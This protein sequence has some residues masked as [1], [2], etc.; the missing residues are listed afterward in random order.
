M[1]PLAFIKAMFKKTT[2]ILLE[3]SQII[4]TEN[5]EQERGLE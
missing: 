1:W 4:F 2:Y 3:L 5:T